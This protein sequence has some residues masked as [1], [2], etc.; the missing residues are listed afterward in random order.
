ME[1]RRG[2]RL[3]APCVELSA[4][5]ARLLVS[6]EGAEARAWRVGVRDLLW[7]GETGHWDRIAP[8]LFPCV[9]WSRDGLVRIDGAAYPMPVHGFAAS[10]MFDLVDHGPSSATFELRD[11]AATRTHFPFAF[12]LRVSYA[13]GERSLDIDVKVE[14]AG[15]QVMPYACGLHPGFAWPFAGGA[16][17]AHRI[18]FAREERPEVPVI[19]PGGL[20]S[21]RTRRVP[22]QGRTLALEPALFEREALCFLDARSRRVALEGPGGAIEAEADGFRHWALWSRPGAPFLCIEAW[23]GHGDPEGFSG[24][25]SEKPSIDVLAPGEVRRHALALRFRA[26]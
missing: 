7:S 19:A 11:T 4:G 18:R 1:D 17:E 22:L 20:F 15:A 2:G 16:Q 3:S 5:V 12:R 14:N 23:T 26:A 21:S 6:R 24:A 25:L 8:I 13:L 10:S 9:G